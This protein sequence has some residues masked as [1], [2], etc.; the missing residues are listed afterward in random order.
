MQ[1]KSKK[2]IP[3]IKCILCFDIY[4]VVYLIFA[5]VVFSYPMSTQYS[6]LLNFPIRTAV[7]K[8]QLI[9]GTFCLGN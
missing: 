6:R 2:T 3:K 7:N 4:P 1:P 9:P 5:S 8:D